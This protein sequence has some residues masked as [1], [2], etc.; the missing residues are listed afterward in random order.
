[1]PHSVGL[2]PAGP[3]RQA[4]LPA[5]ILTALLAGAA[6]AFAQSPGAQSP[7]AQAPGVQSP[8]PAPT[9]CTDV[10]VGSA[11][12]YDCINAQLGAAAQATKPARSDTD[13]PVN[14]ASPSNVVGT[15][16][17]GATRN[18]L[19][20]NFGKSAIPYRPPVANPPA[21]PPR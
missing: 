16:N 21:F 5:A 13:A 18:R 8:R 10:Q 4:L 20:Q 7:G 2:F 3:H 12:S 9:N 1:M 6:P 17:E 11:Q 15:F 19:G 14:A